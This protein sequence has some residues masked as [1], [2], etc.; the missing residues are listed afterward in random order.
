MLQNAMFMEKENSCS[1]FRFSF[2][3]TFN[4]PLWIPSMIT[5]TFIAKKS[6]LIPNIPIFFLIRL[7]FDDFFERCRQKKLL[8]FF[9]PFKFL[10]ICC[11]EFFF[12]L[13]WRGDYHQRIKTNKFPMK[14]SWILKGQ[15]SFFGKNF[16][17]NRYNKV[18]WE[19]KLEYLVFT[20]IFFQWMLKLS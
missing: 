20:S 7:Y 3:A 5:L 1:F 9:K 16:Q 12:R 18:W 13:R 6:M 8:R 10:K 11:D 17:R 2:R 19:K 14:F 4:F 15:I